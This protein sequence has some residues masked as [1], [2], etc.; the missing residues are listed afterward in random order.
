MIEKLSH[1]LEHW[2]EHSAEHRKKY[3][4]WAD[5]I[6][7]ENKEVAEIIREAAKKF[8]E[9]EKLLEKARRELQS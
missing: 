2:V 3:L 6:E 8:E 1:L 7:T 9:G 4:E 5:K